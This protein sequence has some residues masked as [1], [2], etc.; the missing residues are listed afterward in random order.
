MVEL[1][2]FHI[3]VYI[4]MYLI[5]YTYIIIMY[6]GW[7]DVLKVVTCL[8]FPAHKLRRCFASPIKRQRLNIALIDRTVVEVYLGISLDTYIYIFI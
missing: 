5:S 1:I 2:V 8:S 3:Y 7:V 6:D 4:Y